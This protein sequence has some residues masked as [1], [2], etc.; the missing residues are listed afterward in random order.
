MAYDEVKHFHRK[1]DAREA[2]GDTTPG[3]FARTTGCSQFQHHLTGEAAYIAYC[4][5]AGVSGK[6]QARYVRTDGVLR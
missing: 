1:A 6:G 4:Y 3:T 5:V 2:L